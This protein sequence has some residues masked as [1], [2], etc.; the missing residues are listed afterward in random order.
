LFFLLKQPFSVKM[1]I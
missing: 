1:T